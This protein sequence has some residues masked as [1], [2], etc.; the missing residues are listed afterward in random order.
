MLG[1]GPRLMKKEF[2][3]P[4]SHKGWETLSYT[5]VSRKVAENKSRCHSFSLASLGFLPASP[6]PFILYF[7]FCTV[8]LH[9]N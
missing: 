9:Q 7:Y 4:R 6:F 8:Y 5:I 1:P 3:M 2:T